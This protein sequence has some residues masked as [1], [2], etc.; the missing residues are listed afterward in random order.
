[1]RERD[2]GIFWMPFEEF[3]KHY[4]GVGILEII[5]GAINNGVS[6]K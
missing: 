1:V 6:V 5:P 2:D 3:V 4:Q